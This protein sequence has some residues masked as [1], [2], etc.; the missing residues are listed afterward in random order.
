MKKKIYLTGS[1]KKNKKL[2]QSNRKQVLQY[3]FP[4]T[5][6]INIFEFEFWDWA[7][8]CSLSI[9]SWLGS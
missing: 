7:Y 3:L 6:N 2:T 5:R 1:Q 4:T 8:V 9:T